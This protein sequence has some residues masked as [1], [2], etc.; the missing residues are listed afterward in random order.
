MHGC[1]IFCEFA[2][3]ESNTNSK[4]ELQSLSNLEAPG[5]LL[6]QIFSMVTRP[7]GN[8]MK[9]SFPWGHGFGMDPQPGIS[10]KTGSY[11]RKPQAFG[12][13]W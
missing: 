2:I 12:S 9:L 11:E 5:Y 1:R 4:F 10:L 6:G 3:L 7:I 8:S 13:A